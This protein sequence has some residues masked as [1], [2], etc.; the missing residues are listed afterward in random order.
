MSA[1]DKAVP[2]TQKCADLIA[3]NSEG[4]ERNSKDIKTVVLRL[5][6]LSEDVHRQGIM[7]E[8]RDNKIDSILEVNRHIMKRFDEQDK[9]K[10]QL[11]HHDNRIAALEHGYKKIVSTKSP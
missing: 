9:M 2:F 5:D 3:G 8:E 1:N 7:S 4:I 6:K 11:S 10:G